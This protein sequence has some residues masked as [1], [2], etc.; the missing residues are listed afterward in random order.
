MSWKE[1][2]LAVLFPHRCC[3]CDQVIPVGSRF[4]PHCRQ[5]APIV[6]PPVCERCGRGEERCICRGRHRAFERCVSPFYYEA[7]VH[8]GIVRL[9]NHGFRPQ[10]QGFAAEMAEVVRREYGGIGFHAMTAVPLHSTDRRRKGFN[11]SEL[12]ARELATMLQVPYVPLLEKLYATKPQ[13]SLTAHQRS[14]NLL[15]AFEVNDPTLLPGRTLLLVDDVIT[16]G[17][18][19]DECAKMLKIYGAEA[20]YAV[21]AAATILKKE[22][23]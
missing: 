12:L 18:T 19:L 22:E 7:Q 5:N 1:T 13:K 11:H 21:T 6:Y 3:L 17:A 14:G 4:C 9:K 15:G 16:T 10:V 23:T 8:T 2:L 20:V